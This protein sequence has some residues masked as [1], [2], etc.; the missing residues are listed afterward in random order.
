MEMKVAKIGYDNAKAACEAAIVLLTTKGFETVGLSGQ[1][2]AT[3]LSIGGNETAARIRV[4]TYF[5]AHYRDAAQLIFS[6]RDAAYTTSDI[7]EAVESA[8]SAH[9]EVAA[10]LTEAE[11]DDDDLAEIAEMTPEQI[12]EALKR[13]S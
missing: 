10:V 3:Y 11:I 1:G 13:F 2:D 8:L 12:A 5:H 7:T 6:P 9:R 4:A